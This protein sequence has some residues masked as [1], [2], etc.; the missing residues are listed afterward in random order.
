M[1]HFKR[2]EQFKIRIYSLTARFIALKLVTS[3]TLAKCI[4]KNQ[5]IKSDFLTEIESI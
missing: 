5:A 3:L 1:E 4:N 2:M